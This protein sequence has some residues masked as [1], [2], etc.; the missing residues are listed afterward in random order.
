M[1]WAQSSCSLSSLVHC[2]KRVCTSVCTLFVLFSLSS[3]FLVLP[4]FIDFKAE[5][6]VSINPTYM[7]ASV[8]SRIWGS[9]D[10]SIDGFQMGGANH[11]QTVTA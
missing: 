6:V 7:H 3:D 5:E 11:L 10:T 1:P 4:G 2:M 9:K 8:W